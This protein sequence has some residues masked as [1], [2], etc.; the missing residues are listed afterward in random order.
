MALPCN[1]LLEVANAA[2]ITVKHIDF[3]KEPAKEPAKEPV[4]ERSQKTYKKLTKNLKRDLTIFHIILYNMEKKADAPA[5][6]PEWAQSKVPRTK[7]RGGVAKRHRLV[8]EAK[9]NRKTPLQGIFI[10]F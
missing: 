4:K 9:K 3:E 2:L 10:T 5:E 8:S 6:V 7:H 1:R